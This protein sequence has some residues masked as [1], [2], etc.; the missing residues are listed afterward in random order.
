MADYYAS[1]SSHKK[2]KQKKQRPSS[3]SV[4]D[5]D[6][7][8]SIQTKRQRLSPPLPAPHFDRRV[9][10]AAEDKQNN[11]NDSRYELWS[12]RLPHDLDPTS[13]E[14]TSIRY[15]TSSTA[16][17][18]DDQP[19]PSTHQPREYTVT[20][21]NN[22]NNNKPSWLLREE[23]LDEMETQRILLP[24]QTKNHSR[25]GGGSGSTEEDDDSP[26]Q[27]NDTTTNMTPWHKSYDCNLN[28][29]VLPSRVEPD[30]HD[31]KHNQVVHVPPGTECE[32]VV[33]LP[34]S[35]RNDDNLDIRVAYAP[36]AQ[37]TGLYRRWK[38]IG[39]QARPIVQEQSTTL[40]KERKKNK[41]KKHKKQKK[42]KMNE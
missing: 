19:P 1:S 20:S 36:R 12:I 41:D 23:H 31:H 24:Q 14:G 6:D 32:G 33:H 2:K 21:S 42:S 26:S 8:P 22:N 11:D 5:H 29:V 10:V 27:Q 17:R 4:N 34:D 18:R 35:L 39:G 13:L 16:R 37:T 38:P 30:D 25:G 3:S 28:L 15:C 40:P 7:T 9:V